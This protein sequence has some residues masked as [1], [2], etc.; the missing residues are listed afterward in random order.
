MRISAGSLLAAFGLLLA[1]QFPLLLRAS[2]QSAGAPETRAQASVPRSPDH[3]TLS[4]EKRAKAIAYSRAQ[5]SLYFAGVALSLAIYG[6]LA[7]A[8]FTRVVRNWTRQISPRLFVQC[9]VFVPLFVAAVRL[10]ESPLEY[11]WGFVLEHRYGLSTQTLVSWLSDWLKSLAVTAVLASFLAWVLYLTVRRSPRRWWFYFWL[12]SLPMALALILLHPLVID[13]LFFRFTPLERTQP[14]VAA[15]IRTMLEHA[16]LEIPSPRIFEMNASRK[17]KV[18]NAYVTGI[19]ASKRVVVWDNAIRKLDSDAVLLVLGHETGHYVLDHI[20]KGFVLTEVGALAGLY[21][22]S[23]LVCGIVRRLGPGT[24]IEGVSD[25]ASLPAMLFVLN[26]IWFLASPIY[27]AGSRYLEH[28]ADQFALEV[29]YGV[30]RDPNAAEARSLQIL[31]EEDLADPEPGRFV[32]FWLYTH[33]PLDERMRF[34]LNYKPWAEGKPMQLV[35]SA[36]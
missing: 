26:C 31:G 11:Y 3:Y 27:C 22:G 15:R 36:R 12:A 1:I 34:A 19:G 7:R 9:L 13:P 24:G 23:F 6:L 10:L 21:L 25:L 29:A 2:P 5:Y 20:P 33:P 17:T 28:Q 8:K 16:G 30:V 32:K 4:P 18:I 35:R 14:A